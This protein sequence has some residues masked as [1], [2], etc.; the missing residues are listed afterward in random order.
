M[1]TK[2]H[3]EILAGIPAVNTEWTATE[4]SKE[5]ATRAV[6]IV[7]ETIAL[8]FPDKGYYPWTLWTYIKGD[9]RQ[10]GHQGYISFAH[11]QAIGDAFLANS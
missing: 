5:T 9:A 10:V 11:A 4:F 8:Q 3:A 2:T 6:R 1:T 7:Q